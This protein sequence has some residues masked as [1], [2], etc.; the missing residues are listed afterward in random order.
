MLKRQWKKVKKRLR[1]QAEPKL[2]TAKKVRLLLDR[3]H[4][5]RKAKVRLPDMIRPVQKNKTNTKDYFQA[6]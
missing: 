2:R 4:K 1:Q 3:L 5:L 6:I